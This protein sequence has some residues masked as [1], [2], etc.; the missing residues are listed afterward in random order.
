MNKNNNSLYLDAFYF[1]DNNYLQS[2]VKVGDD[3]IIFYNGEYITKEVLSL[4]IKERSMRV[5]EKRWVDGFYLEIKTDTAD[6]DQEIYYD[7]ELLQFSLKRGT[8][9]WPGKDTRKAK[10]NQDVY[11]LVKDSR[12]KKLAFSKSLSNRL[13]SNSPASILSPNLLE[14]IMGNKIGGNGNKEYIKLQSGG[15]RL[16]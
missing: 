7:K 4:I 12:K 16:I 15:K 13:G 5:E 6:Y 3:I 10:Y 1:D 2:R 9:I 14:K 8:T 11:F